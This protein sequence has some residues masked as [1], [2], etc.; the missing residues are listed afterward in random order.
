MP[1][2]DFFWYDENLKK[3]AEHG[4]TPE[5]FEEVVT[6]TTEIETSGTG[7]DMVRGET[8]AGRYLICLFTRLDKMTV[9]PITADE[10]TKGNE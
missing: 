8:A 7:S 6:S 1:W 3:V 2:Y 4:V 9:M 10:P 5:E